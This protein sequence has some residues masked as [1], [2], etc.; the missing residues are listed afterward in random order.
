MNENKAILVVEDDPVNRKLFRDILRANGFKVIEAATGK[1]GVDTARQ[2]DTALIL[3]D[4]QLPELN[5]MEA[6]GRL[7]AEPATRDIPALA[8]TGYAVQGDREWIMASGFDDYLSKPINI[9]E[10]LEKVR[11]WYGAA[12]QSSADAP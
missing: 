2:G 5:G 12:A 10:M 11:R 8:L 1:E 4:I 7:K 3:M 6:V 9:D